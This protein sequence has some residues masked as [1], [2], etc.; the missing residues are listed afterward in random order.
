MTHR[1]DC[2]LSAAFVFMVSGEGILWAAG[3]IVTSLMFLWMV[4]GG[5]T[6]KIRQYDPSRRVAGKAEHTKGTLFLWGGG[7]AK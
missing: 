7:A 4:V 5:F 6:M 3:G 1:C 2:F